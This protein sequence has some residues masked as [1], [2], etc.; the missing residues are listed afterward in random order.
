MSKCC[1][2]E[3]QCETSCSTESCK[4]SCDSAASECPVECAT[5]MWKGSFKQAMREAQVEILK[6]KILK[7][8]GPMM[9]QAAD[10]FLEAAMACW[11]TQI[12]QVKKHQA[13]EAF[14]SK[15][16]ELW[17]QEKKK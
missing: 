10:A 12:A 17:T 1:D 15:L 13:G 5:E 6:A 3:T 9:D 4:P 16:V 2:S 14:K 11:Q 8:H 7:S